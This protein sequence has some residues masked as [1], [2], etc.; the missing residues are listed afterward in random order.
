MA[1]THIS[2]NCLL[3]TILPR[4]YSSQEASWVRRI[5]PIHFQVNK[6]LGSFSAILVL[7]LRIWSWG[8]LVTR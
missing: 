8:A 6:M 5:F 2:I 4:L 1:H 7:L 3:N